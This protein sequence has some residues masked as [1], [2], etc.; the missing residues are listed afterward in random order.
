M[1]CT[2]RVS[3]RPL[4][5]HNMRSDVRMQYRALSEETCHSRANSLSTPCQDTHSVLSYSKFGQD[6]SVK[7]PVAHLHVKRKRQITIASPIISTVQGPTSAS[8]CSPSA[9]TRVPKPIN[10]HAQQSGHATL[11]ESCTHL[12]GSTFHSQ[13]SYPGIRKT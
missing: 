8:R 7:M 13:L 5:L 9:L 10:R 11:Y 6:S 2:L 1:S 12:E 4:G 3:V